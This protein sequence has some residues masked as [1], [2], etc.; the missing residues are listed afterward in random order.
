MPMTP[1]MITITF[2]AGSC[3]AHAHHLLHGV[4]AAAAFASTE[5]QPGREHRQCRVVEAAPREADA[6]RDAGRIVTAM[7][8]VVDRTDEAPPRVGEERDDDH[9][10]DRTR[11]IAFPPRSATDPR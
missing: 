1:A 3:S 9:E 2:P 6:R 4:A 11:P 7:E 8:R 5:H 10:Q